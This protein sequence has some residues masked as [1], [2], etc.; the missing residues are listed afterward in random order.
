MFSC[1]LEPLSSTH[2][3]TASST[4]LPSQGLGL[5]SQVLQSV[6]NCPGD[7]QGLLYR[8]LQLVRGRDS[9]PTL[10]TPGSALLT[11]TGSEELRRWEAIT[12]DIQFFH[13][14]SGNRTQVFLLL[15]ELFL[16]I[17][18]VC[19]QLVLMSALGVHFSIRVRGQ[20]TEVMWQ[21]HTSRGATGTSSYS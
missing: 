7:V 15:S 12:L 18:F 1:L 10:I 20:L 17:Q 2:S 21:G 5:L 11:A 8:V 6:R 4:V 9:S 13:A 14:G 3:F 16:Q 19:C